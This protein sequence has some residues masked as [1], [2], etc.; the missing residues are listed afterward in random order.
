MAC[1]SIGGVSLKSLINHSLDGLWSHV[2]WV[3]VASRGVMSSSGRRCHDLSRSQ[4][5]KRELSSATLDVLATRPAC[6]SS[7]VSCLSSLG[8]SLPSVP[9]AYEYPTAVAVLDVP[10]Y[11]SRVHTHDHD[12]SEAPDGSPDSILSSLAVELSPISYLEPRVDKHNLLR[13]GSS[14]SGRSSLR[15]TGDGMYRD[16]GSGGSRGNGN[17][18]VGHPGDNS[19]GDGTGGGDECAGGVVHLARRS[20]T[21]GG[22]SEIGGDGDGVVMARSLLT[23]VPSGRDMEA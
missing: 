10:G 19:N 1:V 16:G 2:V 8:E 18:A 23:S 3:G 22:D 6:H 17:A 9:G 21:E 14:D 20:P 11:G 5:I 15:S 7:L 13:G 4:K 12:G